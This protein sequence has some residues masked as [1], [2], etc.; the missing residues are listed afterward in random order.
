MSEGQKFSSIEEELAYW[1]EKAL[2]YK[3]NWQDTQEELEEFQISSREL[4]LELETQ[5]EQLETQ[6]K[7]LQSSLIKFEQENDLLKCRLDNQQ[8]DAYVT[9]STLQE[10]KD[11]VSQS[12]DE[13]LRYLR[14]LEQKNDDLERQMRVTMS[15]LED[16]DSRMSQQIERNALLESELDEKGKMDIMCQRL[17]DEVRDL[18]SEIKSKRGPQGDGLQGSPSQ[19]H[20]SPKPGSGVNPPSTPSVTA[21]MSTPIGKP[22]T[23]TPSTRINALNMVGDLLRK[24]GALESRLASCRS[25]IVTRDSNKTFDT[26]VQRHKRIQGSRFNGDVNTSGTGNVA[27]ITV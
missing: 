9:I 14:E 11:E 25:N 17:K 10:E 2:E 24:V 1:K 12:R 7:D 23:V 4:E 27:T 13:L 5:L 3:K 15:T 20:P 21:S 22:T 26:P 18:R 8:S 16:F 6:T 19:S